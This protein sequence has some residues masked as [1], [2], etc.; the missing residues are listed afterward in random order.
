MGTKTGSTAFAPKYRLV[1]TIDNAK[2]MYKRIDGTLDILP[3]SFSFIVNHDPGMSK[4]VDSIF[5]NGSTN[6]PTQLTLSAEFVDEY[7]Q[8]LTYT[9]NAYK[10]TYF[11]VSTI[12]KNIMTVEVDNPPNTDWASMYRFNVG[13]L[14]TIINPDKTIVKTSIS[15]VN[16]TTLYLSSVMESTIQQGASIINGWK[17]ATRLINAEAEDNK[18]KIQIW[19]RSKVLSAA[20]DRRNS[21][22]YMMMDSDTRLRGHW[23]KIDVKSNDFSPFILI[24]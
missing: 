22:Q 7:T 24:Q 1:R 18:T 11:K 5:L 9:S 16:G 17:L 8:D 4:I 13:D 12:S 20:G 21:R 10:P 3:F 23:C 19:R 15:Y 6:Y 2:C 14:L